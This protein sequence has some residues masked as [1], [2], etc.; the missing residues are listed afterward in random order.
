M[1]H[2]PTTTISADDAGALTRVAELWG[3]RDVLGFLVWRDLKIRYRQTMLGVLWAVLQP[4][5]MMALFGVFF[6]RLAKIPSNGAP[7]PLF[8][9]LGLLPWTFIA[10]TVS[11]S[12]N[13][14]V[15]N[16]DLITKVY[17]PRIFIPLAAVVAG[18]VDFG[19][20]MTVLVALL[21]WY[22]IGLSG[23]VAALIPLVALMAMISVAIGSGMAALNVKYRDVRYALPF[24]IQLWLFATPVIYPSTL[25]P[26]RWRFL[27]LLNPVVGV[28]EGFRAAVLGS[29]FDTTAIA[30][31]VGVTAVLLLVSL[32]YF[33]YV[34]QSFADVI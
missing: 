21:L 20:A 32:R 16:P 8:A 24:F 23:H 31:S 13:S 27:Q 25:V 19:I 2:R 29:A 22:G 15:S 3:S 26:S 11:E 4:V 33:A 10:N 28:V 30:A 1:A 34:E 18:L 9:F 14:L 5:L 7:Y 17:V 6:G 12:G